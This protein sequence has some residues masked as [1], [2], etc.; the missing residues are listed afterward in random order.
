MDAAHVIT[1]AWN[2]TYKGIINDD[3]LNNLYSNEEE[4]A[5]NFLENFDT[6][7]DEQLVLEVDNKVLGFANV[8]KMN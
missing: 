6:N 2:E 1:I 5:N 7:E 3:I 4:R 8:G